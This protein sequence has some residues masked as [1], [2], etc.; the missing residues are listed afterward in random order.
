MAF[1]YMFSEGSWVILHKLTLIKHFICML[2]VGNLYWVRSFGCG[3][4]PQPTSM[5]GVP[6]ASFMSVT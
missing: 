3:C 2:H 4:D 6:A 5:G 1:L